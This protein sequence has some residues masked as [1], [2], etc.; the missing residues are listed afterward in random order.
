MNLL[1]IILLIPLIIGF[2]YG[3]NKGFFNQIAVLIG[4]VAALYLSSQLSVFVFNFLIEKGVED[5][6]YLNLISLI[7]TFVLIIIA[8]RL[9]GKLLSKT[10]RAIGLG[11]F[12]RLA[13]GVIGAVKFGLIFI[14]ILFFSRNWKTPADF[15]NEQ[16][17]AESRVYPYYLEIIQWMENL[18]S[19]F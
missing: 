4:I 5:S 11:L 19:T 12:E 6:G 13:G 1:D 2:I 15:F 14:V 18:V 10:T 16:T 3:Y 7:I 17:V 8:I 9:V